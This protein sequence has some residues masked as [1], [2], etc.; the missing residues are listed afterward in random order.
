M[1]ENQFTKGEAFTKLWYPNDRKYLKQKLGSLFHCKFKN[2]ESEPG[3]LCR[4]MN[5]D[6][7]SSYPI[8]TF[9]TELARI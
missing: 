9:F 8:E 6:R 4:I 5:Y 2:E 1:K 7:I 3:N